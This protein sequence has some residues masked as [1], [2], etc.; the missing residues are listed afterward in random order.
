MFV[1]ETEVG[2]AAVFSCREGVGPAAPQGPV[3]GDGDGPVDVPIVEHNLDLLRSGVSNIH[4]PAHFLMGK[5]FLGARP[6]H[7]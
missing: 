5:V 1:L 2:V 7:C 3:L 6:G 4:R